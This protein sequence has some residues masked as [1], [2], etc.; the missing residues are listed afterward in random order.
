MSRPLAYSYIRM[1]TNL[2]I[3]GDSLRRQTELS[4]KYATD[5]NLELVKDFRLQDIGVS[6]FKGANVEKGALW[7]VEFPKSR[8]SLTYKVMTAQR[9]KPPSTEMKSRMA[10]DTKPLDELN[11]KSFRPS[12][13]TRKE[14]PSFLEGRPSLGALSRRS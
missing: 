2:Q 6:A 4:E 8:P 3:K 13:R 1:S 10:I 7:V 11:P 5:N 14:N 9:T 12:P